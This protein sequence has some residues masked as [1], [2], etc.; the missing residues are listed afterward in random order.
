[1]QRLELNRVLRVSVQ[2]SFDD[3]ESYKSFPHLEPQ[4]IA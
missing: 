4:L 1:L 3:G 2:V